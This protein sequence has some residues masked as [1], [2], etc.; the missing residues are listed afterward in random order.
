MPKPTRVLLFAT[1]HNSS[2][3]Y[4]AIAYELTKQLAKRSD[5]QLT[6]FGFQNFSQ[7]PNHR[8]DYPKNVFVYD[9]WANEEPKAAGFGVTLVKDFVTANRPDVC[10]VYNDMLVLTS[11]ISQLKEVPK[12]NFKIIAYIDQVYL[13]QKKEYIN[14]VNQNADIAMLFTPYWEEIA[15][16]Q[17]ITIPTCHLKH[18]FSPTQHYPIPKTLARKFFG[19]KNEDF[20]V[21]NLNRNQ[22]RKRWDIC[23]QAFADICKNLPDEPIKLLVATAVQGAWNILEIFE[24]ELKKRGLTLQDGMKHLIL[25]DNPQQL[26]DEDVNFLYNTADVGINT[27]DG[28]GFGLCN[29]Q[30]AGVGIP[31]IVPNIG[32]FRDFFNEDTALLIEPV[33]TYYVD[34]S[35]DMVCGE[36]ELCDYKDFAIAIE[37]YYN[38]RELLKKHGI[39]SRKKISSEYK[40]EE[41]GN[42]LYNYIKDVAKDLATITEEDEEE[43]EDNVEDEEININNLTQMIDQVDKKDTPV[44]TPAKLQTRSPDII[45]IAP[46]NPLKRQVA[47]ELKEAKEA[48]EA[49]DKVLK[50]KS[51]SK[52]PKK[53]AK[54]LLKE[55]LKSRERKDHKKDDKKGDI[56]QIMDLKSKLDALIAKTSA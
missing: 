1:H 40:W 20:I 48:K 52:T 54:D 22:P 14:F 47:K 10:I 25:L 9:A 46:L 44:V 6:V 8:A 21:L 45:P 17:G 56:D 55:K 30:Q 34:N 35:R 32:G 16:E 36:A 23:L 2:N 42:Q 29:F 19:L 41:L 53:S 26:S 51:N 4:S 15:K 27:C 28:E 5:I 31:Q 49:S 11:I 24:R 50:I 13:C 37:K 18:G 39:N 43:E 33:M 7:I 38:D 12:K 3:G